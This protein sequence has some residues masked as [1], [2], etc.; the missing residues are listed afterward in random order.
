L[1]QGLHHSSSAKVGQDAILSHLQFALLQGISAAEMTDSSGK[2]YRRLSN[3]RRL[4]K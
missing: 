2:T 1:H 4:D 3:L